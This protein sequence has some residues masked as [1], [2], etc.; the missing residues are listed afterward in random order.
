[1]KDHPLLKDIKSRLGDSL[2][3]SENA[4]D[5]KW[6][7]FAERWVLFRRQEFKNSPR[8]NYI[9]LRALY[10]VLLWYFLFPVCIT[11]ALWSLS[12][13]AL[14]AGINGEFVLGV[15]GWPSLFAGHFDAH[16][17]FKLLI[18]GIGGVAFIYWKISGA[19]R[20]QWQYCADV[21]NSVLQEEKKFKKNL[22]ANSL[23]IDLVVLDLWAHRLFADF[24]R[25]EVAEA[26]MGVHGPRPNR[27]IGAAKRIGKGKRSED[28]V[29]QLL[30]VHHA[31][32]PRTARGRYKRSSTLRA[33]SPSSRTRHL[34]LVRQRPA[35]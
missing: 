8:M 5:S 29:R 11:I 22:L 15:N 7:K 20:Q 16:D 24:F 14:N 12:E 21:Y 10:I 19:V 17:F 13:T 35:A 28:F 2:K 27:A 23:A 33:P 6:H 30:E 31:G 3:L 18:G 9:L 34:R 32:L 4:S 26:I 25:D 1:M